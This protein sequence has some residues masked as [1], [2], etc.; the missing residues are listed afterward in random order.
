MD[1][2]LKPQKGKIKFSAGK[3]YVSVQPRKKRKERNVKQER[4]P[5]NFDRESFLSVLIYILWE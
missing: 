1:R 3:E 4:Y 5:M 2:Q